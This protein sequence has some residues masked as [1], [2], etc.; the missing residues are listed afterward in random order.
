MV[1]SSNEDMLRFVASISI[2]DMFTYYIFGMFSNISSQDVTL[3]DF[4][5]QVAY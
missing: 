4:T 1:H 5:H 2:A 3:H